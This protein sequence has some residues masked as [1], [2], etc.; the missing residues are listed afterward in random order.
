MIQSFIF[1]TR[2]CRPT[3]ARHHQ[4]V[5]DPPSFSRCPPCHRAGVYDDLGSVDGALLVWLD[6]GKNW[7]TP[8]SLLRHNYRPRSQDNVRVTHGARGSG[9]LLIVFCGC[10]FLFLF[11][12]DSRQTVFVLCNYGNHHDNIPITLNECL[13]VIISNH[14]SP[15]CVLQPLN[16]RN[17]SRRNTANVAQK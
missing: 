11:L 8:H 7:R 3:T 9:P 16:R 17:R 14:R 4:Q 12:G 6:A 10:C 5:T 1:Q 13:Y 2:H 15:L